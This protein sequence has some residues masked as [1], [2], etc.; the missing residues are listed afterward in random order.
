M[1]AVD[2]EGCGTLD[3]AVI[4]FDE[5]AGCFKPHCNSGPH[6][7]NNMGAPSTDLLIGTEAT[8]TSPALRTPQ[9]KPQV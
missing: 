1:P 5:A 3:D 2:V 7:A 8:P 9:H 6:T 4:L